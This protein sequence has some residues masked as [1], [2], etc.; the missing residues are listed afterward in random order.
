[1]FEINSGAIHAQQCAQCTHAHIADR[2][3]AQS[4]HT[5][6]IATIHSHKHFNEIPNERQ[7]Y[8]CLL[9]TAFLLQCPWIYTLS[10]ANWVSHSK[11]KFKTIPTIFSLFNNQ[12]PTS[13]TIYAPKICQQIGEFIWKAS[14]S[15]EIIYREGIFENHKWLQADEI[16]W[17]SR[18]INSEN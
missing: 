16:S 8:C 12:L 18:G 3:R 14:I 6:R 9:N 13:G 2:E 1:M 4:S 11:A 7:L 15:F 5:R 17:P 10:N